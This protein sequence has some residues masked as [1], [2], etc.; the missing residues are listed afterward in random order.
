M[1]RRPPRTERASTRAAASASL[2][3]QRGRGLSRPWRDAGDGLSATPQLFRVS[4]P[5]RDPIVT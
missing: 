4:Q 2:N 1:S 3:R 5:G